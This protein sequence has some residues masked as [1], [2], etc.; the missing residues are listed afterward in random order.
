MREPHDPGDFKGT[1]NAL[2][3]QAG[4]SDVHITECELTIDGSMPDHDV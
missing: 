1:L 4:L 2:G 3:E